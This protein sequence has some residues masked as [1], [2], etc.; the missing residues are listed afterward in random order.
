MSFRFQAA[1]AGHSGSEWSPAGPY[2][3]SGSDLLIYC[4]YDRGRVLMRLRMMP[5]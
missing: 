4:W 1:I 3:S 5:P 2:E